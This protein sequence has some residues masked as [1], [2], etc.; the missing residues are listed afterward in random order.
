MEISDRWELE[1]P[2]ETIRQL[3]ISSDAVHPLVEY[4]LNKTVVWFPCYLA[5][6]ISSTSKQP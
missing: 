2:K 1:E 6:Y 4:H 5:D 3:L